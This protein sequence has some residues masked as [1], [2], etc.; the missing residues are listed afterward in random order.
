MRIKLETLNNKATVLHQNDLTTKNNPIIKFNK[1]EKSK[2]SNL[3]KS[4][5]KSRMTKLIKINMKTQIP[6]LSNF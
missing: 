6:T 4:L 3:E 2:Y 1:N 5:D